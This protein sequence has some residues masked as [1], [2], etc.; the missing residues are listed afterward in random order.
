[1]RAYQARVPF[2]SLRSAMLAGT[3]VMLAACAHVLAGGHLPAAGIL[4]A[5][6]A[7]TGLASTAVTRLRLSFPA[8]AG[9]LGAGQFV[10]HGAFTA[11]GG[12]LPGP[13]DSAFTHHTFTHYLAPSVFAAGPLEHVPPAGLD[14]ALPGLMFAGH[15]LATLVYAL[16]LARGEEAMWSLAAWLRPLLHRPEPATHDVAA[17]PAAGSCPAGCAPLPWRTLR[18]DCRRGPPGAV[19]FS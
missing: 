17:A 14:P 12:T 7:L 11:F 18:L 1:V 15:A 19:V 9:L 16:L 3:M 6:L 4:L 8:M 2:H 10:L 13:A 5:V